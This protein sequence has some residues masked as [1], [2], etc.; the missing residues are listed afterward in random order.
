MTHR[1]GRRTRW[2]VRGG[3]DIPRTPACRARSGKSRLAG[4]VF[5]GG[6]GAGVSRRAGGTEALRA[7]LAGCGAASAG[8]VGV[9]GPGEVNK[10]G[11]TH[12][13][14]P[15]GGQNV[16]EARSAGARPAVATRWNEAVER[17]D[18]VGSRLNDGR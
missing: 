2:V 16:W 17:R 4:G 13:D 5:A 3:T 11:R 12:D 15:H 18:E 10:S 7:A 8:R 6:G 9:G 14:Q 1:Q